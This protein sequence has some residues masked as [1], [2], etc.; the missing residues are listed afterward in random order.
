MTDS[1]TLLALATFL[2]AVVA[3]FQTR[4]A[5]FLN[6][7]SLDVQL[8]AQPPD[9]QKIPITKSMGSQIIFSADSYYFRL[10]VVNNGDTR[11]ESVEVILDGLYQQRADGT[12][13]IRSAFQPMNL[14]WANALSANME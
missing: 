2:V 7:P 13:G 10:A 14:I 12:F 3:A 6:H 11:A 1:T 8:L 9:C 4:I 5:R